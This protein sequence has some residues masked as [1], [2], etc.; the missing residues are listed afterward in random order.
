MVPEAGFEPARSKAPRD[1]KS[2]ASTNSATPAIKVFS[3]NQ[4]LTERHMVS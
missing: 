1:F 3:K 4:A 2:L